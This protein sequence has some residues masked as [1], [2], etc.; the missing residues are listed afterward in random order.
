MQDVA[1]RMLVTAWR[2]P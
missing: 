1:W 2:R